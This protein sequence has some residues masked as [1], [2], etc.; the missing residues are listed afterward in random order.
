MT[1]QSPGTQKTSRSRW[2][3]RMSRSPQLTSHGRWMQRMSRGPGPQLTSHGRGTLKMSRGLAT[4]ARGTTD[5]DA[6]ESH[7]VSGS[8]LLS[9]CRMPSTFARVL[10]MRSALMPISGSLSGSSEW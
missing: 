8:A 3:Q 10:L 2:M 7:L 4:R 9:Q 6:R 5:P 1:I